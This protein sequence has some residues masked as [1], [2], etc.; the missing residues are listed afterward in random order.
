VAE[1]HPNFARKRSQVLPTRAD[2]ET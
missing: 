2:K 1:A